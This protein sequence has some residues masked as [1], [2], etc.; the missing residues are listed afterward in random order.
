MKMKLWVCL[1]AVC[2][3]LAAQ[4]Y[5]HF[6]QW[7]KGTDQAYQALRKMDKKVGPQAVR[8]A[9]VIGGAY[10]EM[11]GFFRQSGGA[12]AL[13]TSEEGKAA[14]A[15]LAAAAYREDAA[16]AASAYK[17]VSGTCTSCHNAY[18][19]KGADGKFRFKKR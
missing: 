4:E 18:R 6:N 3:T 13:K 16:A 8:A 11:I 9:E 15:M 17:V 7:M 2:S 19:E 14:A 5:V 10:E 12:E 1:L